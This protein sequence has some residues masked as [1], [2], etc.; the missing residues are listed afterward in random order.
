MNEIWRF[1]LGLECRKKP[2]NLSIWDMVGDALRVVHI[3][4]HEETVSTLFF[5]FNFY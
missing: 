1:E 3:S 2:Q 5:I 4:V